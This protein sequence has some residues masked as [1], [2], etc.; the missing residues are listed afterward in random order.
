MRPCPVVFLGDT[1]KSPFP[2]DVS[3]PY[4]AP[5]HPPTHPP[6]LPLQKLG[7][8]HG[9]TKYD[10]MYYIKGAASGAI[11]CSITHASLCP[12]DV[13]KTRM[14]LEPT[15]YNKGMV[16]A[17]KQV[18]KAEGVGALASGLGATAAGYAAGTT[19][20]PTYDEVCSGRTGH[21]EVVRVAFDPS[22]V[23]IEQLL[24]TFWE[25]HDP[26]QG[27]RQGNDVGTQYRSCILTTTPEQRVIA[28][29]SAV[30]FGARLAAS[31]LNA[32][33]TSIDALDAFYFAEAYHQ[34]YL[35]KNPRGY[36][37]LQG[38]GVRCI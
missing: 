2:R 20:N 21:T 19:P 22:L 12:V 26:T 6:P 35:H 23:S 37:G 7:G 9:E 5:P 30:A 27:M 16:A 15:V 17:F 25:S 33:T 10:L 3:L 29:A 28:D 31:G 36:C 34:Q 13:V 38:T 14:Q 4:G 18:I 8:G 24:V 32:I 11:C 1:R